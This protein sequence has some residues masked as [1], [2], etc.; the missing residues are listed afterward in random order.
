MFWILLV[1]LRELGKKQSWRCEREGIRE[2]GGTKRQ[3]RS[4]LFLV[5]SAILKDE[6]Y[7]LG[8]RIDLS[9]VL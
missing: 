7:V 9:K 1:C 2:L 8:K 5:T 3:C 6:N 4:H